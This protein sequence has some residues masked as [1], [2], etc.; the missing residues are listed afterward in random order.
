[1]SGRIYRKSWPQSLALVF[2]ALLVVVG[3]WAEE[4][5]LAPPG[6]QRPLGQLVP[7]DYYVQR[8]VDGDTIVLRQ[9]KLRVRLQGI[10]TPET[11]K[12]NAAVEAWGEEASAYTRQFLEEADWRVRL[13][14]DGE[15]TDRYGRH[16]AFVWHGDRL[17]ND[18]L[19]RSGLARAKTTFDFSQPM[20]QR[21]R[22][23]ESEARAARR[24]IWSTP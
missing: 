21:L 4:Y 24:G 19:V 1:M 6:W 2:A 23:A 22:A 16:L 18:E 9:N 17:L 12:P 3:W 5:V 10:D 14:I 11:V 7:G 15:P 8:V 13:E 20:K